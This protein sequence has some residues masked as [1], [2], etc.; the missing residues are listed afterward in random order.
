MFHLSGAINVLLFLNFR[1]GLLLFPRPRQ[2]DEQEMQVNP[3]ED[4]GPTI[5]SVTMNFQHGP[6]PTSAALGDGGSK[7]IATPPNVS[8]RQISDDI[9]T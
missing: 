7:D 6:G 4:T 1:P 9:E 8:P 5:V 3:Q 2:L